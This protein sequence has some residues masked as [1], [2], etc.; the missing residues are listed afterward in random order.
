VEVQEEVVALP[1]VLRG[2]GAPSA[3][4][5]VPWPGGLLA[6]TSFCGMAP[7]IGTSSSIDQSLRP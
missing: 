1:P 6:C 2:W 5:Q 4:K 3:R 7:G